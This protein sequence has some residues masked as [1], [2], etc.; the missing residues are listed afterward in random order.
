MTLLGLIILTHLIHSLCQARGQCVRVLFSV[1]RVVSGLVISHGSV[2]A[3]M[4]VFK[5]VDELVS[6]Q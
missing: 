1:S 3:A 2:T 5:R 4:E 6:D